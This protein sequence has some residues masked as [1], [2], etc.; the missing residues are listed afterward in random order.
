MAQRK[1]EPDQNENFVAE[2]LLLLDEHSG[3]QSSWFLLSID[4]PGLCP[5]TN[6]YKNFE[7]KHKSTAAGHRIYS[8]GLLGVPAS[9]YTICAPLIH[10]A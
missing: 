3:F 4:E 10:L 7:L 5:Y 9:S 1:K 2:G 8:S 6:E